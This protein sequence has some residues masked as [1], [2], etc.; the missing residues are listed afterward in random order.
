MT[1]TAKNI[2]KLYPNFKLGPVSLDLNP[3]ECIAFLG[4]NGAGKSTFF[5][6]ITGQLDASSGEVVFSGEKVLPES[7]MV[8]RKIGYL[9]QNLDLPHWVSGHEILSYAANLYEL[10]QSRVTDLEQYW[11]ITPYRSAALASCSHGMKKRVGL[12]MATIH[13]P[14]LLILDEPF[15][16]LD[17]L[18]I[19]SLTQLLEQRISGGK[20]TILSTHVI[21]Y[22]A[23]ICGRALHIKKG[24]VSE[25]QDWQQSYFV[26]RI[27]VAESLIFKSEDAA[28][29]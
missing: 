1:L 3:G 14:D 15:S 17:M 21:P 25:I 28:L 11:A 4:H 23:K 9:P 8:K 10:P 7:F 12:A 26:K 2:E 27:E 13:D 19:R 29:A 22:A 6:I 18:H 20:T 24:E 16:G 5:Q